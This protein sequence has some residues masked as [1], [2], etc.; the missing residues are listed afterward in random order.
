[1]GISFFAKSSSRSK[2]PLFFK[3]K[4]RAVINK[5][6]ESLEKVVFSIDNLKNDV[7]TIDRFVLYSK[8]QNPDF[9][10]VL[11]YE[12]TGD[13]FLKNRENLQ[14]ILNSGSVSAMNM[15]MQLKI[16]SENNNDYAVLEKN[17][18][19]DLSELAKYKA[20]LGYD[21]IYLKSNS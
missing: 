1:M 12:C 4:P 10:P 21:K 13:E 11:V 5:E 6:D 8:S 19:I 3:V 2:I 17:A 7:L 16:N 20:L 15:K 14:K 18:L 9:D